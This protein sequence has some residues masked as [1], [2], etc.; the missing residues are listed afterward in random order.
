MADKGWRTSYLNHLVK[1]ARGE[2]PSAFAMAPHHA[3]QGLL[4]SLTDGLKLRDVPNVANA[5]PRLSGVM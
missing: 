5:M 3:R 4:S 1:L 2:E